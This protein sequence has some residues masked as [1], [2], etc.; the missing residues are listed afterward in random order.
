MRDVVNEHA[1]SD[2]LLLAQP[3]GHFWELF[4]ER[5]DV[6]V[7]K[8]IGQMFDPA[9][10]DMMLMYAESLDQ[11]IVAMIWNAGTTPNCREHHLDGQGAVA[12]P[13]Y[14]QF[15]NAEEGSD[16]ISP[17][18][19]QLDI[20]RQQTKESCL[21][22]ILYTLDAQIERSREQF[23]RIHCNVDVSTMEAQSGT[24][25]RFSG[26]DNDTFAAKGR[27]PAGEEPHAVN[28]LK[29]LAS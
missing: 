12:V 2:V 9:I 18:G 20:Y 6:F 26:A 14:D 11:E 17:I 3:G 19:R 23:V 25:Q 1:D 4:L 7:G 29:E 8:G 22:Y 5:S 21:T 13:G 16:K 10:P 24:S 15:F 28:V 27:I